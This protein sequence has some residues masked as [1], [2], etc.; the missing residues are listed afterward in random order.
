M[1]STNPSN[2]VEIVATQYFDKQH[3]LS[4]PD[5][6]CLLT[7]SCVEKYLTEDLNPFPLD[8]SQKCVT[9]MQMLYTDLSAS[10]V[11]NYSLVFSNQVPISFIRTDSW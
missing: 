11:T 10:T 5:L 2:S 1:E 7:K 6:L 4:K 3:F 9:G 8:H